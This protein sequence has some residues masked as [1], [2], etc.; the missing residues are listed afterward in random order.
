MI[1]EGLEPLKFNGLIVSRERRDNGEDSN[2][3][4]DIAIQSMLSASD[5]AFAVFNC[6]VQS[7]EATPAPIVMSIFSLI[8]S[9]AEACWIK[10]VS[11]RMWKTYSVVPLMW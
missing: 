9:K 2:N 11:R 5:T 4:V 1:I 7:F 10:R 8:S 3:Y 6:S